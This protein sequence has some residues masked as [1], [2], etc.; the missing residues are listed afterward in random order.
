MPVAMGCERRSGPLPFDWPEQAALRHDWGIEGMS[1]AH[2]TLATRLAVGPEE[3]REDRWEFEL[4]S[5][6]AGR[7]THDMTWRGSGLRLR[8]EREEAVLE[9]GR[10]RTRTLGPEFMEWA[11][12]S[13]WRELLARPAADWEALKG[14]LGADAEVSTL[15]RGPE[16]AVVA[17][18][19]VGGGDG[20]GAEL[21]WSAARSVAS[22]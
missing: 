21:T 10:L 20:W 9:D 1:P 14:R 11:D 4:R 5:A 16:G 19:L 22:P 17:A 15:Q 8:R 7:I 13:R 6:Q 18:R 3:E 2:G 12:D